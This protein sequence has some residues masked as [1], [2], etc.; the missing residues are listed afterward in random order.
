MFKCFL[1]LFLLLLIILFPIPI[2]ITLK[3]SNKLL[4]IFI[5]KKKLNINKPLK[6]S[7]KAN[8]NEPNTKSLQIYLKSLITYNSDDMKLISYKIKNLKL[9][10]TLILNTKVEYGLDDA[11]VVAILF[12]SLYTAYSFLHKILLNFFKVKNMDFNV[13]PHFE[14]NDLHI[15]ISSIIYISLSKI[16]YTAFKILPCLMKIKHN[17][18]N[19]KEYKGGNVHG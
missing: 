16:I 2:K 4:E 17:K 11:A 1:I 13:I 15:E 7:K 14:E 9:M 18:S 12:G 19:M 3:Y 5:Y 8:S 6:K 10:P